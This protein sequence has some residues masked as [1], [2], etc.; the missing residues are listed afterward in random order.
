MTNEE[1]INHLVNILSE[2]NRTGDAVCYITSE[3]NETIKTAIKALEQQHED[4]ISRQTAIDIVRH[5]C[6]E[7]KGLAKEIVKQF[8]GLSPVQ[9]KPKTGQWIES[10][11][12]NMISQHRW[13][14]SEC[15]GVHHDTETGEW[16]EVFDFK[17]AYCPLCGARMVNSE[18]K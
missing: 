16:R 14:C 15:G 18:V 17:Y 7:W 8:N 13:Y 6:G 9:P 3:D 4:A 5:E 2:A 10:D 1:A 12:E 11:N